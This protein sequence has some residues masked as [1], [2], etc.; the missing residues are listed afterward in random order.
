MDWIAAG[1]LF[2]ILVGPL[3]LLDPANTNHLSYISG[4]PGAIRM[5]IWAVF[6]FLESGKENAATDGTGVLTQVLIKPLNTKP[7]GK[8]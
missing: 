6:F 1:I 7:V 3:G 4:A 8:K 2:G 5:D